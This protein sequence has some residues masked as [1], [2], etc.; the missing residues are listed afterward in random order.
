[1]VRFLQEPICFD[2][3]SHFSYDRPMRE[4]FSDAI[5]HLFWDQPEQQQ[6]TRYGVVLGLIRGTIYPWD[7]N[8][9]LS[10]AETTVKM[11]HATGRPK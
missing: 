8:E 10:R 4:Q 11:A 1:M 5:D 9:L 7:A 3:F 6:E 2:F